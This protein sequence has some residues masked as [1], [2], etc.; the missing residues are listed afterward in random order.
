MDVVPTG[1]PSCSVTQRIRFLSS[2]ARLSHS[3]SAS[4]EKGNATFSRDVTSMSSNHEIMSSASSLRGGRSR[5]WLPWITGPYM[6]RF[7][8]T[9]LRWHMDSGTHGDNNRA[10]NGQLQS[11]ELGRAT[12]RGA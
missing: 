1:R 11:D 5:N 6:T 9:A 12:L 2:A 4:S 8:K 7:Y 10:R 3:R